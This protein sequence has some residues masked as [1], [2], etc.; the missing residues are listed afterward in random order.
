VKDLSLNMFYDDGEGYIDLG[1]DNTLE[2]DP[3]GNLIA[4]SDKTWLAIDGQIVAYYVIDV[5]GDENSYAITGRV[6]CLLNGERTNLILVFDSENED[7]YVA[8]ANYDYVEGETDTVAKNLTEINEGDTIDFLCD[9]YGYD[10]QFQDSY[11]LGE[12]MTVS[13]PMSEMVINN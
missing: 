9:Y 11:Y 3:D 5:Q 4:P 6:P 13:H 7:G 1:L 8:G 10:K 12:Q 2:F